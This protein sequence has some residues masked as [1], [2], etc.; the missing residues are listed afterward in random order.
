MK[1]QHLSLIFFIC[2][3][4][5][6]SDLTSQTKQEMGIINDNDLYVSVY[7]DEFYTNGLK[8]YYKSISKNNNSIFPKKIKHFT[9]EQNIF[10]P[11]DSDVPI[12][13]L[14]ERPYAGFLHF[15][16]TEHFINTK[17][18]LSLG[19]S[20]GVTNDKSG[21]EKAQNFIHSF[22]D[23]EPSEGWETQI[24]EKYAFGLSGNYIRNLIQQK[25]FALS[26]LNTTTMNTIVSDISSGLA[27]RLNF[28]KT[29]LNSI[30][31][32]TFWGT[33]L[34]NDNEKWMKENYIGFKSSISY[35]IHDYTLT[36]DLEQNPSNKEFTL[37]PWTWK[38]DLGIYWGLEKVNFSYHIILKTREVKEMNTKITK[39]GSIHFS[40]KF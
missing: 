2:F 17:N 7:L 14:Q 32:S 13:F 10:N 8:L 26:L 21:A 27:L 40:Y 35:Q 20:V 15:N 6:T 18:I 33:A 12:V 1:T 38:N 29:P 22:Y 30:S 3:I 37:I 23:L 5:Y 24:I 4:T 11:Q 36:G 9:L 34:Q 31:N 39:Y 28:L 19:V 25:D 16:Y